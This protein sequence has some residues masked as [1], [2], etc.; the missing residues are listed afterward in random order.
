METLYV[1]DILKNESLNFYDLWIKHFDC[2]KS[3][4]I[5]EMYLR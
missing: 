5:L 1:L 2:L 4:K 3:V